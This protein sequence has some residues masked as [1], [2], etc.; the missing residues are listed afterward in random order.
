V[1]TIGFLLAI[2]AAGVEMSK[3]AILLGAL[4]V[5]IGFG[6]QNIF[7]NLI[8]GIIL[9][10]ERPI[11]EGDVIEVGSQ[12]GVVK[13]IGIRASTIR[14][15]EGAEV[16]VPNGNLISNE[17]INWTL[18]DQQRRAELNVGVAY[19]TDPELVIQILRDCAAS[20]SDIM[21]DPEPIPIF[22]AFG[23][24]SLDFR[25]LF[26]ITDNERRL[27]ILSDLAVMINAALKKAGITIPFPQQDLHVKTVD[28]SIT[29][30]LIKGRKAVK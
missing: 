5:G 20:H 25:L 26:W 15:W 19:G 14:T 29:D 16:I 10:F 22:T 23:S 21:K 3:L 9:A 2:A 4:G 1:I 28:Q 24:S 8:S 30:Q 27:M 18:T 7:N 17:L 11:N 12:L 13:Q 6:L